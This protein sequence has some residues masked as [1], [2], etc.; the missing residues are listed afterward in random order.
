M[1]ECPKNL[2]RLHFIVILYLFYDKKKQRIII[3]VSKEKEIMWLSLA[4]MNFLII[5]S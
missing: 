5:G 4:E 1:L 2:K 3:P